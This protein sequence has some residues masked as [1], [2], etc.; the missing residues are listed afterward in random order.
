M[1]TGN[2]TWYHPLALE[3]PSGN[4]TGSSLALALQT[5]LH[6]LMGCGEPR[7]REDGLGE[8]C[9]GVLGAGK[10]LLLLLSLLLSL[11]L[12]LSLLLSLVV[13]VVVVVYIYIYIYMYIHN[14]YIYIYV[15]MSMCIYI[16]I[17]ICIHTLIYMLPL[18]MSTRRILV[19]IVLVGRLGV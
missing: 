15:Y 11:S 16:Y 19:W 13:V 4:Y 8:A 14:I 12:S 3:I 18:E 5:E 17:Y 6:C 9:E 2:P 1:N 7:V 10:V